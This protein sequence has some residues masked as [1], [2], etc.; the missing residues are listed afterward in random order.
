MPA[1]DKPAAK[2]PAVKKPAAAKA[3]VKKRAAKKPAAKKRAA[4]G[5]GD[6]PYIRFTYPEGLHR[7]T[8][9]ILDGIDD[10]EDPCAHRG[11]LSDLINELMEAGVKDFFLVP[12]AKLDMGMIVNQSATLG[13]NSVVRIMNPI[14]R[15]IVGRLDAR[16]LRMVSEIMRGMMA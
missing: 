3:T 13:A 1:T 6:R 5:G 10:G 14:L 4:A 7:R 8:L 9:K 12:L 16:R 11:A 15:N 2:K